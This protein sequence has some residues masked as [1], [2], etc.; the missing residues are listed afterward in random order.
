MLWLSI[1]SCNSQDF[2]IHLCTVILLKPSDY[3]RCLFRLGC[4]TG[5]IYS[6]N[7]AHGVFPGSCYSHHGLLSRP[8][9]VVRWGRYST[10][11]NDEDSALILFSS[12]NLHLVNKP[13]YPKHISSVQFF[14]ILGWSL[15]DAFRKTRHLQQELV[16]FRGILVA[17]CHMSLVAGLPWHEVDWTDRFYW[18][19][20]DLKE[21]GW[22]R[23]PIA[24][25]H[26]PDTS[27]IKGLSCGL[28]IHLPNDF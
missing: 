13:I 17:Y 11:R 5:H 21:I 27:L 19:G 18:L 9:A 23:W 22:T 28:H 20:C 7:P 1:Q 10:D 26:V 4:L 12:I 8:S 6:V 15:E 16:V 3:S 24:S 25:T 2:L 14:D